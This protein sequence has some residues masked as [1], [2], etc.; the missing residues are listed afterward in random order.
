[1]DTLTFGV[2]RPFYLE[3]VNFGEYYYTKFIDAGY[4]TEWH[5]ENLDHKD[6]MQIGI[7]KSGSYS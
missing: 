3:A 4:D 5:L 7:S 2:K 6:L 1:M